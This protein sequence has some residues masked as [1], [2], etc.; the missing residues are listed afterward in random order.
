MIMPRG[1]PLLLPVNPVFIGAS[2]AVGLALNMLPLGRIAWMP[3][4]LMVLLVF[5]GAHQPLR[6]GMGTAFVLGLC[7]DVGQS[8]LL[9]QH[10]LSYTVLSF[11]A[12]A[13]HRRLLWFGV[14]SQA[15]QVL[16]LFA[17][18]HA[19]ELLPRLASGGIFPG[20]GLLAAPLLE[21]LLWPL[22]CGVL[23]APQRRPPDSDQN[24]PL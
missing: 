24:R 11:A 23:L 16:P 7:M 12:V 18:A 14:P 19:L 15:L 8:T 5:W 21:A 2:L 9:G 13:I 1:E 20:P 17:L 10:A 22:A 6:M 3:D 4:L